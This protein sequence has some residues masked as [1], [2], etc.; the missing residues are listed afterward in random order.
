MYGGHRSIGCI[1]GNARHVLVYLEFEP[2][3][4]RD[5]LVRLLGMYA[6]PFNNFPIKGRCS[7][8][9]AAGDSVI[10]FLPRI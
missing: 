4:Q 7:L 6:V 3:S 5:T 8:P 10:P 9:D 2:A 1:A